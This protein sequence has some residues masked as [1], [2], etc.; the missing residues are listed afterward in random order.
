M[1]VYI[2]WVLLC[3]ITTYSLFTQYYDSLLQGKG[4]IKKS[5]QIVIIGQTFYL[6]IASI[7]IIAGYGLVAIVSAQASSVIIVRW[8]SY[9]AFFS[10]EMKQKLQIAVPH[11]KKEVLKALVPNALKIGLTSLGGFLVQRSAIV[12]GSLY[13][14]LDEI[15]SYG[16]S[17]QLI[18][19]IAGLAGIYI[20]T[21]QPKIA[22]LRV[23][24]NNSFIKELYLKGQIVL[25]FTYMVGGMGLFFFGEWTLKLVGSQ[26]HLIAQS[27]LFVSIVVS[28][29]ECNHSVA[30]TILL[31]KNEVPFFKAS[32]FSGGATV[33]LLILFF[34]YMHIGLWAMI[35]APGLA[36]I[37]YQNWKWPI[38]VINELEINR[39]DVSNAII[40]I[41]NSRTK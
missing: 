33:L 34:Q 32:L 5:K 35:A 22:Q 30:G 25:L 10:H 20:T 12:I 23:A 3:I 14:T 4:L 16:I 36:Q 8:L 27:M 9:H 2:A 38:V 15:A 40:R 1:E 41:K 19:V 26:T 29:L 17:I 28:F 13:L 6:L 39:R 7:L 31:S 11:P 24:Q 18:S 21:Y 37:A